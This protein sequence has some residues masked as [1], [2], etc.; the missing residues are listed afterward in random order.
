MVARNLAVAGLELLLGSSSFACSAGLPA[1]PVE[2]AEAVESRP[3]PK[4]NARGQDEPG[5]ANDRRVDLSWR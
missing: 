2:S 3:A 4:A 5:W 1:A